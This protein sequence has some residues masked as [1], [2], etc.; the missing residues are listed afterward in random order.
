MV[1]TFLNSYFY[2]YKINCKMKKIAISLLLSCFFITVTQAQKA[3]PASSM[4]LPV[5]FKST[6]GTDSSYLLQ[7]GDELLYQV[8][9]FGTQYDF[10]VT[11]NSGGAEKP[12]DFNYRM[13][14]TAG[15]AGHVI[16]SAAARATAKQYINYFTGGELLLTTASTVWITD[17]NFTDFA[18]QKT[19]M[20]FDGGAT[21]TMYTSAHSEVNPVIKIKGTERKLDGFSITNAAFGN[22]GDKTLWINNS[23]LNPLIIKMELGFTI[24]LKEIR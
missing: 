5:N 2:Y 19:T 10:I 9:A 7:K 12:L 6:D 14:N 8:T 21:E 4:Y 11:V 22:K 17:A 1:A 16:I 24:E 18:T 20:A 23:S 15:T 13:T 3:K